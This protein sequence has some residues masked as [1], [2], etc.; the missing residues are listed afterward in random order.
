M[1]VTQ[2]TARQIGPGEFFVSIEEDNVGAATEVEIPNMPIRG[3]V[4]RQVC[5]LD[6]GTAAVVNP[7]LGWKSDPANNPEAVAV[8]NATAAETVDN[9]GAAT[10]FDQDA[11]AVGQPSTSLFHQSRPNA[12]ADNVVS[13]QYHIKAGW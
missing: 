9:A 10:Y 2:I 7:I 3:T 11:A 1:A 13:T 8:E 6:S 12:G 5:I 4:R